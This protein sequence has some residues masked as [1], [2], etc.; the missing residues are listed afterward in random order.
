[1]KAKNN[2]DWNI[3]IC[4]CLGACLAHPVI[5]IILVSCVQD[6]DERF[7]TAEI[8]Q[9]PWFLIGLPPGW[10]QLNQQCLRKKVGPCWQG[11]CLS[12]CCTPGAAW[13]AKKSSLLAS[14][15]TRRV[16]CVSIMCLCLPPQQSEAVLSTIV[17]QMSPED[18]NVKGDWIDH[19][20]H[21][22][23]NG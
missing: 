15:H 20:L 1:M 12:G 21:E 19:I 11:P 9:H 3:S 16:V 13:R 4:S 8:M 18:A 17:T 23:R 2:G 5:L 7:G 6:P 14:C 22:A 10:D